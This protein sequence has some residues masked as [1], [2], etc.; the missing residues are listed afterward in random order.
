MHAFCNALPHS[1]RVYIRYETNLA[2]LYWRLPGLYQRPVTD[3][4]PVLSNVLGIQPGGDRA[5]RGEHRPTFE[6]STHYALPSLVPGWLRP[7]AVSRTHQ[8]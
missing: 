1:E 4:L 8:I 2:G 7:G 6:R 5:L 3:F